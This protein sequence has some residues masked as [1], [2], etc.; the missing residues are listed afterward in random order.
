MDGFGISQKFFCSDTIQLHYSTIVFNMYI[1]LKATFSGVGVS[2][3]RFLHQINLI[4]ESL[5]FCNARRLMLTPSQQMIA[6]E[7]SELLAT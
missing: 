5:T 3:I 2:F 1:M 7:P 4:G 6:H